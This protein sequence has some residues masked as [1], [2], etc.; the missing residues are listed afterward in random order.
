MQWCLWVAQRVDDSMRIISNEVEDC[1]DECE[2]TY[3][4]MLDEFNKAQKSDQEQIHYERLEFDYKEK[5]VCQL[6]L[7]ASKSDRKIRYCSI[8]CLST[9]MRNNCTITVSLCKADS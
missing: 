3:K 5:N 6:C 8:L 2:S 7:H 1:F 4:E 9:A